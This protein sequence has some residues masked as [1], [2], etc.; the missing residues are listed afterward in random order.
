MKISEKEDWI[1][2]EPD[3]IAKKKLLTADKCGKWMYFANDVNFAAELCKKAVESGVVVQ[4]KHAKKKS[5]QYKRLLCCF[6][7]NVDDVEGHVKTIQFFLDNDLIGKTKSG[8]L[9]N[10][11]FK[12]DIQTIAE[13][14]GLLKEYTPVLTLDH[15]LDLDTGEWKVKK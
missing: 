12:L 8:R 2:Y 7:L 1:Y 4:A 11:S 13:R 10:I 15:F 9:R 3:S 5:F 6:Y 14:L